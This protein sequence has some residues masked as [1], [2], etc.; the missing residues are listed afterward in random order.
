LTL[1]FGAISGGQLA[2]LHGMRRI[3][4]LAI[5]NVVSAI[6]GVV[7]SIGF[8]WQFGLSGIV[9]ALC[10]SALG[11]LIV[12]WLYS[13]R[14]PVPAAPKPTWKDSFRESRR[15][16]SVGLALMWSSLATGL[17]AL[18][19][20]AMISRMEGIEANGIYGAAWSLSGL[21]ANFVLG[22]MGAD[23]CPRL[24][25]VQQDH[26]TMCR[27]V[28]EQAEVAILLA[29]PGLVAT[30]LFARPV[31]EFFLSS[32]FL[33]AA[34]LLPWFA[35]GVFGRVTCWPMGYILIAKGEARWLAGSETFFNLLH[36]CLVWAGLLLWGLV[37]TAAAFFILYIFHNL[38]V[39]ILTRH[40]IGY[41]CCKSVLKL[42]L[43]SGGFLLGAL[44]VSLYL[45]GWIEYGVGIVMFAACSI[46]CLRLL[47]HRV[48]FENR[49]VQLA[50]K[51]PG[52]KL[53]LKS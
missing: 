12:S 6:V 28:N 33:V 9:P 21:L 32:E 42:L 25:Q 22:A 43:M 51:L 30:L 3:S 14:L 53:I 29:L 11:A 17:A 50:C 27:L 41:S 10:F 24:T 8:Y 23:F 38:F 39:L 31:I 45:R 35:L 16:L 44:G 2:L 20:N 19:I 1:L 15:L 4:D 37:A 46:L 18:C 7:I 26:P 13:H 47:V 49:I 36:I 48:G 52:L 5:I 40:L 34:D